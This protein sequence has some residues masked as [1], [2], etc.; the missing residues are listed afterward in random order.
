LGVSAR[1]RLL[2]GGE[3]QSLDVLLDPNR[4]SGG[5]F[6]GRNLTEDERIALKQYLLLL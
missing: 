4:K 5:H 1:K 2:Y 6:V 3:A